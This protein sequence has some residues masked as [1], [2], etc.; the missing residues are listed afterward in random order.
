MTTT[1]RPG[2]RVTL[3]PVH[4][5]Y[6]PPLHPGMLGTVQ[7]VTGAALAV[8]WDG[9]GTYGVDRADVAPITPPR[10]G[11]APTYSHALQHRATGAI[12]S[13]RRWDHPSDASW[14]LDRLPEALRRELRTVAVSE[15]RLLDTEEGDTL[16]PDAF[17]TA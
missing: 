3:A 6:D 17:L 15:L 8:R 14:F 1:P 5:D 16:P 9:I 10:Y 7:G 4:A 12:V 13:A 11:L 2:T